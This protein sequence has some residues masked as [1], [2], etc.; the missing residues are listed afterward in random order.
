MLD[1]VAATVGTFTASH[2][3]HADWLAPGTSA[4]HFSQYEA[5]AA[6]HSGAATVRAMDAYLAGGNSKILYFH[7]YLG[8][9]PILTNIFQL[10]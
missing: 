2:I 7:P 1:A 10:G 9:I 4:E 6:G 3:C 8:K 5:A